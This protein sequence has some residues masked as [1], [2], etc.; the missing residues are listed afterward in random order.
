ML[1]A[2]AGIHALDGYAAHR[3]QD[4]R[5]AR[6]W[7][8]LAL[9]LFILSMDEVASVHERV[10]FIGKA[11]GVNPAV[12]IAPFGFVLMVM[13][14]YALL[15]L[16]SDARHR[17][18][19]VRIVIAFLILGSVAGQEFLELTLTWGGKA[20]QA[21][22]TGFE[23]ATELLG[24]LILLHATMGHTAGLAKTPAAGPRPA[25]DALLQYKT[26]L[27]TA[28]LIMAP[29]F[30]LVSAELNDFRGRPAPWLA[31]VAFLAAALIVLRPLFTG[32]GRVRWTAWMLAG[33]CCLASAAVVTFGDLGAH[34][35][36]MPLALS[37][38]AI[39]AGI[40]AVWLVGAGGGTRILSACVV[41]GVIAVA[42]AVTPNHP[43]VLHLLAQSAGIVVLLVHARAA[44]EPQ[45][46]SMMMRSAAHI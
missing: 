37:V 33:L 12:T 3:H 38:S 7:L 6:G 22:R 43:A 41:L 17:G 39:S 18:H 19:V 2:L 10:S 24:I 9:V 44:T 1:L 28:A 45:D 13:A 11:I 30:A 5:V 16:W 26:P 40:G 21:M 8:V 32:D 4:A 46:R 14:G 29:A 42:S 36:S 35:R 20:V 31:A 25:F 34:W 15:L 23:E 27:A